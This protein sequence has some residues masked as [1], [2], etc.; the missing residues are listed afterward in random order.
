MNIYLITFASST[1]TLS[2]YP[3]NPNP[4]LFIRMSIFPV[5]YDDDDDDDDVYLG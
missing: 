2:I 4:A 3:P 5:I 1:V